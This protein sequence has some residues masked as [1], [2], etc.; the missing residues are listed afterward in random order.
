MNLMPLVGLWWRQHATLAKLFGGAASPSTPKLI[1][2]LIDA[3]VPVIK[4]RFP[5]YNENGLIDDAQKTLHEVLAP[6]SAVVAPD[7]AQGQR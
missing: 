5:A 1:L 6:D 7:L 2:E 4:R 3:N